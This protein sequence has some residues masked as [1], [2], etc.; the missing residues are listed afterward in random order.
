MTYKEIPA[1]KLR[2]VRKLCVRDEHGYECAHV[3]AKH[4]WAEMHDTV[5]FCF[6]NTL[7]SVWF[8][9]RGVSLQLN[10]S[11]RAL[12]EKYASF[13]QNLGDVNRVR[14]ML[15]RTCVTSQR[16]V[17]WLVLHVM[18]SQPMSDLKVH[19]VCGTGLSQKRQN[20]A[21]IW[22][23]ETLLHSREGQTSCVLTEAIPHT[24]NNTPFLHDEP[25]PHL[26][27]SWP[28]GNRCRCLEQTAL[29]QGPLWGTPLLTSSPRTCQLQTL[30]PAW[31]LT[32]AWEEAVSRAR[33]GTGTQGLPWPRVSRCSHT[34]PCL[35]P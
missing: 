3:G 35:A 14:Q 32:R 8:G 12:L 26:S 27:P 2:I 25:R 5:W 30:Q 10:G 17:S 31:G 7:R 1:V 29:S 23:R 34:G 16:Q 6:I 24:P 4:V 9:E 19:T 13:H 21:M 22:G 33:L 28:P 15:T 11:T 20:I 18:T